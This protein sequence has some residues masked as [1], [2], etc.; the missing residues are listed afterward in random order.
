M[1]WKYTVGL[2]FGILWV[3]FL[4]QGLLFARDNEEILTE[5]SEKFLA[6]SQNFVKLA[7]QNLNVDAD[8]YAGLKLSAVAD[9]FHQHSAYLADFFLILKIVEKSKQ[10]KELTTGIVKSRLSNVINLCNAAGKRITRVLSETENKDIVASAHD[11]KMDLDGLKETLK[12]I[13]GEL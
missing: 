5:Y 13:E 7:S 1:R 8:Y 2:V 11:L 9:E 6:Y 4:L 10:E 3:G 12:K